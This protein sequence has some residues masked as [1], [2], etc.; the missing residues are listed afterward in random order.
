MKRYIWGFPG[1]G[2][3]SLKLDELKIVD[4]DCRL[5][6][7]KNV[8]SGDL[9]GDPS[10]S[11]ERDETY[12]ENYLDYIKSVDADVVL[13]NCHIGLLDHL[14]KDAVLIVYPSKELIDEYLMRYS[15]RGDHDSFVS[16]MSSEAPEMI[17][18]IESTDHDKYKVQASNTYL[19]D[20]FERNDFKMKLM[21]RKELIEQ[22]QRAMDLNVID[23]VFADDKKTL[24]CNLSFVTEK[25]PERRINSPEVWAA[26]VLDREYDLDIDQLNKVCSEREV[27]IEKEKVLLERR[28]GLTREALADKIMQ[29][30][31][32]GAL[33]IR[34]AEIA[35][36][37]H[38]YEVTFGG[39]APV[40]S[41][42]KYKNRWECYK[43][44]FFDI[45]SKIAD[46][47][48]NVKQDSRAFGD[49]TQAFDINELLTAIDEMESK[50]IKSFTPEEKTNFE[51]W[52]SRGYG[53]R[54]SI[55]T[56]KD[57]H[58]GKGLDGIVQHHYHGDYSSMT[59]SNYNNLVET[60]VF[61]KGFCLDCLNNMPGGPAEQKK[62]IDYLAKHGTD[63][64]SPEKLQEWIKDNPEKCGKEE[65]RRVLEIKR[66]R[67]LYG[68]AYKDVVELD[69]LVNEFNGSLEELCIKLGGQNFDEELF[70]VNY[71]VLAATIEEDDGKLVLN[72][73]S[74]DIWDDAFTDMAQ[75]CIS[76]LELKAICKQLGVEVENNIV[77]NREG[78]T[79]NDEQKLYA[80]AYCDFIELNAVVD[81]FK[82]SFEELCDELGG[83]RYD[84][85]V[86]RIDYGVI[87]TDVVLFT[88]GN[89][90]VND[91]S[92]GIWD[93]SRDEFMEDTVSFKYIKETCEE[94]GFDIKELEA[95]VLGLKKNTVLSLDEKIA[96]CAAKVNMDESRNTI[97]EERDI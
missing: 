64:S 11:V 60:L 90:G 78:F 45:P 22:L 54:G 10:Y 96:D 63:I 4:A 83:D 36:Y 2:K 74:I 6:E 48:E 89:I 55:A 40:G 56:V 17:D 38:G 95:Q 87:S 51:R 8:T 68:Q 72:K 62:V 53:S 93:E 84:D 7:F 67:E 47:I 28:G 65:N 35:P 29:G 80:Q 15:T 85:D 76:V 58:A 79:F 77:F 33:G 86:F 1:I 91:S 42:R 46:K 71:G 69:N 19:S 66:Q 37:S 31:V 39:E 21:T 52:G 30:I 25:A 61:M 18:Y 81:N 5:F 43:G 16:Y 88:D 23:T 41:T 27:Q 34:Y 12:P 13:I 49:K 70:D 59:P 57:V 24:V 92:V 75:D 32:N 14:D 3:S 50:Q 26:A 9:H 94:I 44:S 20:L 97:R 82:G 73:N